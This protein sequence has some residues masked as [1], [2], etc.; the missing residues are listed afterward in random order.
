MDN[1]SLYKINYRYVGNLGKSVKQNSNL[2]AETSRIC[3]NPMIR[4]HNGVE[5]IS[6]KQWFIF[7]SNTNYQSI[8]R[9]KYTS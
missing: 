6:A 8:S 2:V 7:S 3:A 1:I 5:I 4:Y 9:G